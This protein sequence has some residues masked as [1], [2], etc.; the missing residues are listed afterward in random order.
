MNRLFKFG[1]LW[2]RFY[3]TAYT[4]RLLSQTGAQEVVFFDLKQQEGERAQLFADELAERDT[5][6][7]LDRALLKA[8]HAK[9]SGVLPAHEYHKINEKV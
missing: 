1:R 7:V 5:E 4:G 6:D 3:Y 2:D 8:Q 9:L